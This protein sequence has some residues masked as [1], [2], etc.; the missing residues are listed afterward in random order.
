MDY[1]GIQIKDKFSVAVENKQTFQEYC[2]ISSYLKKADVYRDNIEDQKTR[3]VLFCRDNVVKQIVQQL[4][5]LL[6]AVL[7]IKP[8][9]KGH[10]PS[11]RT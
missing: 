11:G 9:K 1:N 7:R 8:Q 5:W 10:V 2:Y 4:F 3:R 6:L